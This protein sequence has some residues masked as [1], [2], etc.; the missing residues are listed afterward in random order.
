MVIEP[1]Y[2]V[3]CSGDVLRRR[4]EGGPGGVGKRGKGRD[5]RWWKEESWVVSDQRAM[6]RGERRGGGGMEPLSSV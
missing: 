4:V 1:R 3:V 2:R 5:G 6:P